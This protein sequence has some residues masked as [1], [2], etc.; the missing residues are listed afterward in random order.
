MVGLSEITR[1]ER[2]VLVATT[3]S[4]PF[5]RTREPL[6]LISPL[7]RST[8]LH[9]TARSFSPTKTGAEDESEHNAVTKLCGTGK[10][11]GDL[12][13]SQAQRLAMIHFGPLHSAHRVRSDQT[14]DDGIVECAAQ[15]GIAVA[16]GAG[17]FARLFQVEHQTV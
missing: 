16:S 15:G 14:V 6:I 12:T 9:R 2:T 11:A 8:S 4:R 17:R 5:S 13:G 3:E 1:R 10:Q 7:A